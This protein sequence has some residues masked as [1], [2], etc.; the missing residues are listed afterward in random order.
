MSASWATLVSTAC[1]DTA[2]HASIH[3]QLR[4]VSVLG[5]SIY[6]A[7]LCSRLHQITVLTAAHCACRSCQVPVAEARGQ[8][9]APCSV[10]HR[11]G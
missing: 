1:R 2:L 7:A 5:G 10:H 9:G 3:Q 6:W 4:A 8:G 11:Q